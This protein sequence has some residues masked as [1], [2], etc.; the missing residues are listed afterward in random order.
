MASWRKVRL[1]QTQWVLVAMGVGLTIGYLFPDSVR[2]RFHASDLQILSTLFLRMVESLIAPLI[3]G[4]LVVG[5]AGHGDDIR[6]IGKLALRALL[7]FEIMTTL[8]LVVGLVAVN[9]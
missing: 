5:I 8:A 1:S 9:L 7:Y 6:R 2:G 3:F 4:T